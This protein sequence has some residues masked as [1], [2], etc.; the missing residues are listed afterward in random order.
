RQIAF[1]KQHETRQGQEFS[2]TRL[3]YRLFHE[4]D[5]RLKR[6]SE[7]LPP[8]REPSR[9]V[10]FLVNAIV[11]VLSK[12]P[13]SERDIKT[14]V[15]ER[16]KEHSI[17]PSNRGLIAGTG[18][19]VATVCRVLF[20]LGLVETGGCERNE[21]EV[22]VVML[23]VAAEFNMDPPPR[24]G[25]G[26]GV[27]KEGV[28]RMEQ[29][30]ERAEEAEGGRGKGVSEGVEGT[31]EG[32]EG[33]EGEGAEDAPSHEGAVPHSGP[34]ADHSTATGDAE[35]TASEA[36]PPS[37][38][39]PTTPRATFPSRDE[40]GCQAGRLL[41]SHLQTQWGARL[42]EYY[43]ECRRQAAAAAAAVAETEG[44][45]SG[46][47][48]SAS[49]SASGAASAA[50]LGLMMVSP[51]GLG[52]GLG[53]GL[54]T[55]ALDMFIDCGIDMGVDMS[56]DG[57]EMGKATGAED[58]L[59]AGADVSAEWD[60]IA[61]RGGDLTG[62]LD[63]RQ[64]QGQEQ[65]SML[66]DSAA[67]GSGAVGVGDC[68]T[69]VMGGG[70]G[71]S[72]DMGVEE[73]SMCMSI[74]GVMGL[75]GEGGA[76]PI[77]LEDLDTLGEQ[78]QGMEGKEQ[79]SGIE[80]AEGA[81]GAEGVDQTR[82]GAERGLMDTALA[83]LD[84]PPHT[85][86]DAEGDPPNPIPIPNPPPTEGGT[87][88]GGLDQN[89]IQ[90][91]GQSSL[92]MWR[93]CGSLFL[94]PEQ[95]TDDVAAVTAV[96]AV[97]AISVDAASVA[98]ASGAVDT[99]ANAGSTVHGTAPPSSSSSSF[100]F[101][102][103]Q[104]FLSACDPHGPLLVALQ[105]RTELSE[106]AGQA[107]MVA[108]AMEVEERVLRRIAGLTGVHL[109]P[110]RYRQGTAFLHPTVGALSLEREAEEREEQEEGEGEWSDDYGMEGGGED[111]FETEIAPA[112]QGQVP[113]Q[114]LGLGLGLGAGMG[115]GVGVGI[116][117]GMDMGVGMG[118]ETGMGV[119]VGMDMGVS[120]GM[121][122]CISMGLELGMEQGGEAYDYEGDEGITATALLD[123]VRKSKRQRGECLYLPG[124]SSSG[125]GGSGA[126]GL[127]GAVAA[128]TA[129]VGVFSG[130]HLQ[131]L[132]AVVNRTA[133]VYWGPGMAQHCGG[134]G[135]ASQRAAL[136]SLMAAKDPKGP[137]RP[138][139]K[140]A[141]NYPLGVGS[142]AE[143]VTMAEFA[144]LLQG[145]TVDTAAGLG[146][147]GASLG[148]SYSAA[149]GAGVGGAG[150]AGGSAGVGVGVVAP[151]TVLCCAAEGVNAFLP[152]LRRYATPVVLSGVD[153]PM[154]PAGENAQNPFAP[155]GT[156][157]TYTDST[158][159]EAEAVLVVADLS[160]HTREM[161][162]GDIAKDFQLLAAAEDLSA[163][164]V[165]G[166]GGVGGGAHHS[167]ADSHDSEPRK[168]RRNVGVGVDRVGDGVGRRDSK[169]AVVEEA[170]AQVAQEVPAPLFTEIVPAYKLAAARALQ[171]Q[172]PR[173]GNGGDKDGYGGESDSE[174]DLSD[175]AVGARHELVLKGMRDKWSH[176]QQLKIEAGLIPTGGRGGGYGYFG[177]G[178]IA[179]E[180]AYVSVGGGG[181][182]PRMSPRKRGAVTGHVKGR[183]GRPPKNLNKFNDEGA[184]GG[185]K[186]RLSPSSPG[187][188]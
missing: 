72:Q 35:C 14:A 178:A 69:T 26:V 180:G 148:A 187:E 174:E 68:W 52:L 134:G 151:T 6:L 153:L 57:G 126:G 106:L 44:G 112:G 186:A 121:D 87:K 95:E 61:V 66:G 27:K 135:L 79:I 74:G 49:A 170:R 43:D 29:K 179:S 123:K 70:L 138:P 171:A 141:L 20:A 34:T 19:D 41:H 145:A 80:G 12:G 56:V 150:A 147:K 161:A 159:S 111:A 2:D 116:G 82:L 21:D 83:L 143:A 96:D 166:G 137:R 15:L 30:T 136:C 144:W 85:D 139:Q 133:E 88:K 76:L 38:N 127:G 1:F 132:A 122:A 90:R 101:P 115:M 37:T 58:G 149:A 89:S 165:L 188:A 64:R 155:S 75:G 65:G 109:K 25:V 71:G 91:R 73:G 39:A 86:A 47:G 110:T 140:G 120:M 53:L 13:A 128:A 81:D 108:A 177:G 51:N 157:S 175:E 152:T 164:T 117:I 142:M 172:G 162:W 36:Q 62:S 60:E 45:S 55:G 100:S 156:N 67:G 63:L 125:S 7:A 102:T 59:G 184:Q 84:S 113:G 40:F 16:C 50:E 8:G 160:L 46:P 24:M 23:Q 154:P 97:D 181:E 182:A 93:M 118:A 146:G 54:D 32:D 42:T 119:S 77:D 167:S 5:C 185:E 124:S 114:G 78:G 129:S 33:A 31:E 176:L 163:G 103:T 48:A 17:R 94:L 158:Y 9:P 183:R 169:A 11:E 130:T 18:M 131:A 4:W 173:D 99:D 98:D 105:A 28:G 10:V 168:K 104:A 22:D 92:R 3:S 107:Y